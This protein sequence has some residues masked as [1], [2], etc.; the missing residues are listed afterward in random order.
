MVAQ[1]PQGRTQLLGVGV[2]VVRVG[3][4]VHRPEVEVGEAPGGEHVQVQVRHLEAGD[5]QPGPRRP[6]RLLNRPADLLGD[7]DAG[8]QQVA[9]GAVQWSTSARG[10]TRVWPG[11]SGAMVRKATTCGSDQTK[12]AGSSPLIRRVKRVV[13]PTVFRPRSMITVCGQNRP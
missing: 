8:G 1:V 12:R 7:V 4:G 10:T 11:V 2:Q 9:L 5:D 6:P 3:V 13:M